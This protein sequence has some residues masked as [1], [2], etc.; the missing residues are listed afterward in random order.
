MGG[1]LAAALARAGWTVLLHH[2]R[3]EVARRAE[4]LGYGRGYRYAHDEQE[5]VAEMSSLP[6]ALRDRIY[7]RPTERGQEA[8]T[9]ARLEAARRIRQQAS[10]SNIVVI[11]GA[12]PA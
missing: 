10:R 11:E 6:D 12:A 7:Y 8:E 1:S 4:Q 3:P 5:G 9:A 2:R